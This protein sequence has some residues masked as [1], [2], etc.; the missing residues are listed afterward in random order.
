MTDE[1][2][3]LIWF[4]TS[5]TIE[6]QCQPVLMNLTER[7][8]LLFPENRELQFAMGQMLDF[9]VVKVTCTWSKTMSLTNLMITDLRAVN[10]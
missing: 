7:L 8:P 6:K 9:A 5:G 3:T 1:N 10:E 2:R 4:G